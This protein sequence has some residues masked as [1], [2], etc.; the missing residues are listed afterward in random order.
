M[1]VAARVLCTR[2]FW[3]QSYYRQISSSCTHT[4][5]LLNRQRVKKSLTVPT[6]VCPSRCRFQIGLL[7]SLVWDR[8]G[9][10]SVRFHSD[11]IRVSVFSAEERR[12]RI[13]PVTLGRVPIHI[14]IILGISNIHTL[15]G[16]HSYFLHCSIREF[17]CSVKIFEIISCF[18][19]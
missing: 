2:Y 13:H 9:L 17:S 10:G 12:D 8:A 6:F 11:L 7:A 16:S 15:M 5:Q 19:R 4:G 14:V 1:I 18:V 3:F